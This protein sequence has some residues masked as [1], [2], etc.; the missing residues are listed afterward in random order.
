MAALQSIRGNGKVLIIVLGIAL[1]AF[2]AEEFVRSLETTKN[3]SKQQ[4][5]KVYDETLT[6]HEYQIMIEEFTDA[7]KFMRGAS[8][9]SEQEQTQVKDQVWQT[10]VNDALIAHE[11][12]KVGLT[13]T[14]DEIANILREGTNTM[15]LQTPFVN[16]QTG[17][18]DL[19]SLQK[20][21]QDYKA[22]QT[23]T[24][25]V[26]AEYVEQYNS[27]YKYWQFIEK[28]LRSNLLSQKFQVLLGKSLISNTVSSKMYYDGSVKLNDI[29]LA[30]I[31]F[32]AVPDAGLEATADE[33]KKMYN[34]KKEFF[35]QYNET[36][37]IEYIDVAITASPADRAKLEKEMDDIYN[38]FTEGAETAQNIV[39]AGNSTISYADLAL[40]KNAFPYDI[41]SQFDSI[42]AGSAKAPYYNASDN[43]LNIIKMIA[44]VQLPD[45]V[46]YSQIQVGGATID[47]ARKTADSIAG[48]LAAG[49]DFAELAKKYGQTGDKQWISSAAYEGSNIDSEGA[50]LISAITETTVGGVKNVSMLQG[51][52]IIKVYD[53]RNFISKYNVAVV[54]RP[55]E[56]S[57]ETYAKAFNDF[58]RFVAANNSLDAIKKEAA[59]SGYIVN[60]RD[61][62][63]SAEHLVANVAGTRDV[64]KWI[65]EAK[66]GAVSQLYEVGN[67]D[68][69]MLVALTK[70]NPE[71]YRSQE[72]VKEVLTQLV[73]ND[74]KAAKVI[75]ELSGG[76]AFAKAQA[77]PYTQTDSISGVSFAVSPYIA[78][79]GTSEPA[80]AGVVN[81]LAQGKASAP[82]KGNA[83]VYV[84]RVDGRSTS[85]TPY[86]VAQSMQQLTQYYMRSAGS[87][88]NDLYL[89]AKVKDKRYLYF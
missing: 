49:A 56:F 76:D 68:H 40:S 39:R 77:L 27:V 6:A 13:V 83:G 69:L 24:S 5:G 85:D 64:L 54:K 12:K 67:N 1:F 36:R 57:K 80:I 21:L 53:R 38:K 19:A 34:D 37:N 52:V 88:I 9:L 60:K 10:F 2:I 14:D 58:S 30:A 16:Q 75:G 70:I 17:R 48:A 50:K 87:F 89:K 33:L 31:P 78:A 82:I 42:A 11:A 59:K 4:I 15:L 66:E 81:G 44:K 47:E 73:L 18:F 7:Y 35:R 23:G 29:T 22:M 86:D 46:E 32:T 8:N 84:V 55:I 74:K 28:S 3:Q 63:S 79:A 25:Q 71:G 41:N 51:N 20:F 72:D 43:S 61:D 62:L 45:S 65:F 26:P